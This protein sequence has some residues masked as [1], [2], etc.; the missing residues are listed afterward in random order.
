MVT[1]F[2][3]WC[4]DP[5]RQ[6]GD[7][8]YVLTT[9]GYHVMFFDGVGGEIWHIDCE[10]VLRDAAFEKLADDIYASVEITYNEDLTDRIT[11]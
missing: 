9:Y 3:D 1:E 11:K 4:F 5:E 8:G 2:N 7:V 10:S 6:E